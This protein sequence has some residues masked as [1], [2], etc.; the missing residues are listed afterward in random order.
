MGVRHAGLHAWNLLCMPVMSECRKQEKDFIWVSGFIFIDIHPLRIKRILIYP[1]IIQISEEY[2]FLSGRPFS[3]ATPMPGSSWRAEF[4]VL[5]RVTHQR[6]PV[7]VSTCVF[8]GLHGMACIS[9]LKQG[10]IYVIQT[11]THFLLEDF[12]QSSFEV[13]WLNQVCAAFTYIATPKR[14]TR[15]QHRAVH[16]V[17]EQISWLCLCRQCLC[18]QNVKFTFI[19]DGTAGFCS[20][21]CLIL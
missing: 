1:H 2:L 10:T 12:G 18:F 3:E 16:Y 19:L 15:G 4:H 13:T 17:W 20:R 11:L 9:I 6:C 21:L 8:R 5:L 14:N 7:T